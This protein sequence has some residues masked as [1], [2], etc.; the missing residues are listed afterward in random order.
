MKQSLEIK[1]KTLIVAISQALGQLRVNRRRHS[2]GCKRTS[3]RFL[4]INR[5]QRWSF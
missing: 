1:V 2:R 4:G 3:K 5:K